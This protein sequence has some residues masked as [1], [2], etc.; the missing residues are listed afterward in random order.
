[1][2][3]GTTN[4]MTKVL[5]SVYDYHALTS[6]GDDLAAICRLRIYRTAD[7][8]VV[9]VSDSPKNDSSITN[10]AEQIAWAVYCEL[11]KPKSVTFVEHYPEGQGW[12]G[13]EEFDIVTFTARDS[14]GRFQEPD[15]RHVDRPFVEGLIGQTV[16]DKARPAERLRYCTRCELAHTDLP[17]FHEGLHE[18]VLFSSDEAVESRAMDLAN[19]RY[20][21]SRDLISSF[22]AHY[23]VGHFVG[24]T[25]QRGL[26][27]LV[28]DNPRY[29]YPGLHPR[30][31]WGHCRMRIYR[32]EDGRV[33]AL[34]TEQPDNHG[35]SI[36]NWAEHLADRIYRQLGQP[37]GYAFIE[38]YPPYS[39][40]EADENYSL[41]RYFVSEH[42]GPRGT[43]WYYL[44]RSRVEQMIGAPLR[45]T[46][47]GE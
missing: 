26:L 16:A 38:H 3:D 10:W 42:S 43:S 34:A 37:D 30:A 13:R 2:P 20:T 33:L 9:I 35:T 29:E 41:V 40:R 12:G 24:L 6:G 4:Q 36:T 39:A 21:H 45:A 23:R 27:T 22:V 15:W 28:A 8:I 5:D 46:E 18:A 19:E 31:G 47:G 11:G 1:M 32:G 7:Q 17:G 44:G 25:Q 14:R